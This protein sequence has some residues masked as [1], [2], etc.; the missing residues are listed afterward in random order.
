MRFDLVGRCARE[1]SVAE[2]FQMKS[3]TALWRHNSA[4][5]DSNEDLNAQSRLLESFGQIRSG[6]SSQ[7]ELG[8]RRWIEGDEAG[9]LRKRYY[10]C[11]LEQQRMESSKLTEIW[12]LSANFRLR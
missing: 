3:A 10:E 1:L 9:A 11:L 5:R 8:S 2:T 4:S 6:G 7:S 12:S